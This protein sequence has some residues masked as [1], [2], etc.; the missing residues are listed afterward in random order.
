[1]GSKGTMLGKAYETNWIVIMN[2]LRNTLG[3]WGTQE[4]DEHPLWTWWE[5]IGNNKNP[6]N[7]T[8]LPTPRLLPKRKK[9]GLLCACYDF[10]LAEQ[11]FYSEF[12]ASHILA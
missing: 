7:P 9:L 8:P 12:C 10:S 5:H 2:M 11:N 1:M 6:K 4:L 3:T